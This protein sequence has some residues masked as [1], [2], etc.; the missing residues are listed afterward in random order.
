LVPG[1]NPLLFNIDSQQRPVYYQIREFIEVFPEPDQA[2]TMYLA[3]RS[4]LVP[5][6]ADEHYTSVDP[7]VVYL[8]ALAEAK[9]HYGQRDA[10]VYFQRLE[11]VLGDLNSDSFSTERFIPNPLPYLPAIPYPVVTGTGWD[12]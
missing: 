5:F 2:Y 11:G 9:A 3:G 4:A 12:R 1:I 7:V 6:T 8:Q 10:Q